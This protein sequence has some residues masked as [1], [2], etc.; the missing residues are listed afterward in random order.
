MEGGF[1][2]HISWMALLYYFR[3]NNISI[4]RKDFEEFLKENECKEVEFCGNICWS[5]PYL[6]PLPLVSAEIID[7]N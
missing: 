1:V 4:D 7:N 6:P 2:V 5:I 3:K